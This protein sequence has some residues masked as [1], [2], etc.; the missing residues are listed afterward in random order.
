GSLIY[1]FGKKG[2]NLELPVERARGRPCP[3]NCIF[4]YRVCGKTIRFKSP[5][6][7][8]VE[9]PKFHLFVLFKYFLF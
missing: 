2:K 4:C 8:A 6:R 7:V 3:F 9:V 5:D 1:G